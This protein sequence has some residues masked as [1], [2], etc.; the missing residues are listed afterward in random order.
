MLGSGI[1]TMPSIALYNGIG[2]GAFWII[3]G[4]VICWYSGMLLIRCWEK[5]GKES[6]EDFALH[7]YGSRF[8]KFASWNTY[9][10]LQSFTV[11]YIVFIKQMIPKMIITIAGDESKVP[12]I[13][14]S[15]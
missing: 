6:Y 14:G 11:S 3:F 8:S 1:I 15:G 7:S 13:F 2:L 12:K 10:C 5:T 9:I 4:A